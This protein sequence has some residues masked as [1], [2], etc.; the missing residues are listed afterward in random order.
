MNFSHSQ[1]QVV[2]G[3]KTATMTVFYGRYYTD[4]IIWVASG[5]SAAGMTG[6]VECT[7]RYK[8]LIAE[9]IAPY[10]QGGKLY[11]V[12]HTS[13]PATILGDAPTSAFVWWAECPDEGL[14]TLI[15][16]VHAPNIKFLSTIG[17]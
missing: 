5:S 14:A 8:M 7:G 9:D 12:T 16:A 3:P 11:H 15:W 2:L 4:G 17:G 1:V 10:S 13:K 6:Y